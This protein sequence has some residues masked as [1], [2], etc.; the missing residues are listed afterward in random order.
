MNAETQKQIAATIDDAAKVAL[1]LLP[2]Q[3]AGLILLGHMAA[4]A[5]PPLY[6]EALRIAGKGE[7]TPEDEAQLA[8]KIAVLANPEKA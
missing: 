8:A 7:P 4:K 3:Y 2:P 5:A 1:E 6:E